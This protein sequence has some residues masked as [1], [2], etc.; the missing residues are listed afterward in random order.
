MKYV[1][2]FLGSALLDSKKKKKKKTGGHGHPASHGCQ[3]GSRTL[4]QTIMCINHMLIVWA[5]LA[6]FCEISFMTMTSHSHV[7]LAVRC[8]HVNI[9]QQ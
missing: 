2:S 7:T 5:N 3:T 8:L 6:I 9:E 4:V 1:K